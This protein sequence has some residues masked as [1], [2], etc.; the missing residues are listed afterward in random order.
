MSFLGADNDIEAAKEFIKNK[1]LSVVPHRE[2][3]RRDIYPYFTCS[4]GKVFVHSL[5][6]SNMYFC[7]V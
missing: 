7:F 4:V 2:G 1:Y 3:M 6:F 5:L